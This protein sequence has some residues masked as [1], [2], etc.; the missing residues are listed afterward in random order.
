MVLVID[1]VNVAELGPPPPVWEQP[2]KVSGV[3]EVPPVSG[4]VPVWD[5]LS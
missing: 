1:D 2:L 3:G 4:L 5:V